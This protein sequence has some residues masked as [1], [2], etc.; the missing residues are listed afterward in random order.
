MLSNFG[1]DVSA[2]IAGMGIQ[3]EFNFQIFQKFGEMGI[4]IAF[5][6]RTLYL[7]NENGMKLKVDM[8]KKPQGQLREKVGN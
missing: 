6:T 7:R 1:Y 8:E 5:P 3:Q 4:S 2:I